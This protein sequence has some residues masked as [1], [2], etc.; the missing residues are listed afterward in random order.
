M[1]RIAK[2]TRSDATR[3]LLGL[4]VLFT[5]IDMFIETSNVYLHFAS[6]IYKWN[7]NK[8]KFSKDI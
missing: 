6:Y 4:S 1:A 8:Q 7:V 5:N 3:E 2:I